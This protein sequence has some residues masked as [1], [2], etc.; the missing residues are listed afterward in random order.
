M[1]RSLSKRNQGSV[2]GVY[3]AVTHAFQTS[4]PLLFSFFVKALNVKSR[5]SLYGPLVAAFVI[6]GYIGSAIFYWRAGNEFS[7]LIED[8]KKRKAL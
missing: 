8:K 5:P 4:A 7:K 1:Q 6:A 2:V 3:S